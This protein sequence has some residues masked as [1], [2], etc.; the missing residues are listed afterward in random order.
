M[1]DYGSYNAGGKGESSKLPVKLIDAAGFGFL[2]GVGLECCISLVAGIRMVPKGSNNRIIK[3]F[4]AAWGIARTTTPVN[5][6][7]CAAYCTAFEAVDYGVT[8]YRQKV[9]FKNQ[10]VSGIICG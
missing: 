5:G 6:G 7:T 9:E 1:G 10:V 4:E 3:G 2:F 8:H